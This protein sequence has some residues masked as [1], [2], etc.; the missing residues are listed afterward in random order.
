[1]DM[2]PVTI[3]FQDSASTYRLHRSVT[4][5]GELKQAIFWA[6]F[7]FQAP[8]HALADTLAAT[9][10]GEKSHIFSSQEFRNCSTPLMKSLDVFPM[11]T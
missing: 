4:N 2:T 6:A 7:P 3:R 11:R 10:D 1:M 9:L 8:P 5:A